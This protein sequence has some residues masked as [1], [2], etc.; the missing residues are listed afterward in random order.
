[1][2]RDIHQLSCISIGV[3]ILL[4]SGVVGWRI[5]LIIIPP[6]SY[7]LWRIF[8]ENK[9]TVIILVSTQIIW[10]YLLTQPS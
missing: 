1:M 9:V 6:K 10:S 4:L 5:L 7:K 3:L 8:M 2:S